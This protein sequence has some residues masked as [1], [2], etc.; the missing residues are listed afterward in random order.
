[1]KQ[2]L[3]IYVLFPV[4]FPQ[5]KR[6]F[7]ILFCWKVK[8]KLTTVVLRALEYRIFFINFLF[9]RLLSNDLVT[10]SWLCRVDCH[11]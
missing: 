5:C 7:K 8:V 3:R 2:L 1:M 10:L 4:S 6:G 9:I 11:Q